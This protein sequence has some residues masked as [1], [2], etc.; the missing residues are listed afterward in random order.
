V[1]LYEML[2]G[3]RLFQGETVSDTLA[4]VLTR[5]PEWTL[6]PP[7]A[8]RLLR[9]CLEKDPKRRLRDIGDAPLLLEEAPREMNGVPGRKWSWILSTAALAVIAAAV[10]VSLW[11]FSRRPTPP[12]LRLS[13]DLGNDAALTPHRGATMALSPDGSRVVF[14]TGQQIVKSK[15]AIRR[16][17]QSKAMP[18]A[19]TEGAEAPFFSPDGKYIAFFAGG[20]LKK[21]DSGGGTPITLCDAPS[22][23]EGSWGDDDNIVFAAT[24]SGGLSIVPAAG[25]TPRPVTKLD[26][27]EDTHRYP[28]MLPA[29][30]TVLFM[31][32]LNN[33]GEG[34]IEAQ[35]LKTGKRKRLAEAGAYPRYLPSG[36]LVY[37]H[38]GTLFAVAM[39]PRRLELS[40][41]PA[42]VLEDVGFYP[43]TGT[44]GFAFA[45][46]GMFVYVAATPEEQMREIGVMDQ[47]GKVDLLPVARARYGRPRVSPDGTR[48]AVTI[49]AAPNI[50]I[51]IYEWRTQRFSRL[52]FAHGNSK[53]PVWTPEGRCL[54]FFSDTQDPGPGIY[55]MRTDGAGAP[56][57]L[58]EGRGLVPTSFSSATGR[59]VYAIQGG[60]KAGLWTMPVDWSDASHPR[61][62]SPE[63]FPDSNMDSPADF[64]PDGHFLMYNSAQSGTPEILVRSYPGA[65]G[66]W[67]ISNRGRLAVWSPAG[68]EL[69]Y[70]ALPDPQLML[71]TYS[72]AGDSFS[73]SPPRPWN[74]TRVENFDLMPDGKHVVIIPSAEPKEVTHATFLL[75][76]M[77]DLRSRL[78]A[79]K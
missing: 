41:S 56:Q 8:E 5:E 9:R 34:T 1:V 64:S 2:T 70:L 28:Q 18:L 49:E 63:R 37:M 57:R 48:L 7:R 26:A 31:N 42:P 43:G 12:I 50:N 61:Q 75:N 20:K 35:S 55:W 73:P 74:D 16:L 40:G 52:P 67:Q 65:G 30:Q 58:L 22:P 32:G 33:D 36:H 45:Q 53:Y 23:R 3:R 13:V 59:L 17:D 69:F 76:F 27:G 77:D 62:G 68:R 78:P 21:I 60:E 44:A 11:I 66:P 29:A 39:N 19:G 6:V 14:I 38:Q 51:W 47:T 4:A 46:S 15:L 71:V 72:L 54:V 10:L 79:A 25:G 24:N